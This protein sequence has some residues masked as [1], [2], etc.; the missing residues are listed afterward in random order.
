ME[1]KIEPAA[2]EKK[3]ICR[4]SADCQVSLGTIL[5]LVGC[6]NSLEFSVERKTFP[7]LHFPFGF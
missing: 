1:K 3:P 7:S 6:H 2:V 5:V 4:Q